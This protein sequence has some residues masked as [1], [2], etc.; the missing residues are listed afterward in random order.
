MHIMMQWQKK[1]ETL[2]YPA[3]IGN[4]F[5][6][7]TALS[8][9]VDIDKHRADLRVV[10]ILGADRGDQKWRDRHTLV[11]AEVDIERAAEAIWQKRYQLAVR[12]TTTSP[13]ITNISALKPNSYS[14]KS[15]NLTGKDLDTLCTK[16][17]LRWIGCVPVYSERAVRDDSKLDQTE[18]MVP[19]SQ[20]E[21]F[22]ATIEEFAQHIGSE[23]TVSQIDFRSSISYVR[24]FKGVCEKADTPKG[25]LDLLGMIGCIGFGDEIRGK[26]IA[27]AIDGKE[28]WHKEPMPEFDY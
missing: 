5:S 3:Q 15:D 21:Q 4:A 9:E 17:N 19:P 20:A 23:I 7:H 2:D 10:S 6:V 14:I 1:I 24:A 27:F 11:L 25:F 12:R 13:S 22:E 28:F 8:T 18:F 16:F 26:L